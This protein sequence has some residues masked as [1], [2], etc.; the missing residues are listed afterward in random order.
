[1]ADKTDQPSIHES[2]P[3]QPARHESDAVDPTGG[4]E[5]DAV[6]GQDHDRERKQ[7]QPDGSYAPVRHQRG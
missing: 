4:V 5:T 3:P 7:E 1:M 2:T 6:I